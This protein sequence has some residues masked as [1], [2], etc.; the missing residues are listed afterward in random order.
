MVPC[1]RFERGELLL[2][3]E[4]TLPICPA[5]HYKFGG[6]QSKSLTGLLNDKK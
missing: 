4:M 6:I 5:G 1:P 2:L 3:R